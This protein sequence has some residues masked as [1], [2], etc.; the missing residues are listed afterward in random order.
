MFEDA[1]VLLEGCPA[2][3]DRSCYRC[4]RSFRNRFEHDLLDRHLGASLLGYLLNG[5]PPLLDEERS[6]VA[7]DRV[8]EDLSRLDVAGVRLARDVAI[9]LPGL[10][11]VRAPILAET[12]ARRW[13][14][15]IHGPLTPDEPSDPGLSDAKEYG[16][17]VPVLLLDEIVIARN[18]PRASR[19][20]ID[21]VN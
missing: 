21:A 5:T 16:G 17:A 4:L 14:I 20:V 11:V 1:L 19:Q 13:I 8:F 9:E 3:C 15:G 18:L 2:N 6:R 12:S 7:A 10:G